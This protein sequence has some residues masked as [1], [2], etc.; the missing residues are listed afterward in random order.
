M[1]FFIV[2]HGCFNICA[3]D[4]LSSGSIASMPSKK[5]T[6]IGTSACGMS[7]GFR[8]TSSLPSMS[9]RRDAGE[10]FGIRRRFPMKGQH[11]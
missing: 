11:V 10:S 2:S 7:F 1:A 4:F 9:E 5:S 3:A 8:R 6:K